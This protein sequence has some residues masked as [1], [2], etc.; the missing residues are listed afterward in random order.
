ME[1]TTKE[2]ILN[3]KKDPCTETTKK[4]NRRYIRCSKFGEAI[5]TYYC[6]TLKNKVNGEIYKVMS[7]WVTQY[8]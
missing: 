5:L 2:K 4:I 8:H 6:M 1:A 3:F 7:G